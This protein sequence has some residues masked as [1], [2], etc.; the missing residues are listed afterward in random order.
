MPV[1]ISYSH[2]DR[3]FA[4]RFAMQLVREK[5]HVW[6]DKWELH[7]GDSLI[8]KIQQA[9]GQAS[10][11][12]V[13][14]SKASAASAWCNKELNAGLMRELDEKRVVVVPILLEDCAIP[15]FLREKMYADF[16]TDFDGGF[17][18]VIESISRVT[19]EYQS[20]LDAPEFHS[21]WAIDWATQMDGQL[22]LRL[23]IS[24]QAKDQPYTCLTLVTIVCST[25]ETAK[26]FEREKRD[27][28]SSAR[29]Y[30]VGRL[31][32]CID[33]GMDLTVRLKD[34]FEQTQKFAIAEPDGG[35]GFI[36]LVSSRRMGVDTGR[37]TLLRTG[38]QIRQI[39]NHMHHVAQMPSQGV[40][41]L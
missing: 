7:A 12:L 40:N 10:A 21:D 19:N 1:F 37:D 28:G 23:T 33:D 4:E 6:F 25:L 29:R 11:L 22:A 24:E 31:V 38:E 39:Y 32:K 17:K 26:Y 34:Q 2:H 15:I 30:I 36:V 3:D 9:V 5:V 35:S 13:V 20:R 27:G 16:R 18:T 14:L 41:S 8:S